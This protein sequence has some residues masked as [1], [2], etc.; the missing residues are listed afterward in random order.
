MT[1][2]AVEKQYVLVIDSRSISILQRSIEIKIS[3]EDPNAIQ[4]NLS[5]LKQKTALAG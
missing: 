2:G 3:H 5:I 4:V 1:D